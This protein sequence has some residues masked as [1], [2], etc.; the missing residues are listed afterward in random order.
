MFAVVGCGGDGAERLTG[1]EASRGAAVFASAGCG[2]CHTLSDAG[3]KGTTGPDLDRVRLDVRRVVEQV[4]RGGNGMPAFD[5]ELTYRQIAAV[6]EY[7]A[8]VAG[9]KAPTTSSKAFAPDGTTVRDCRETDERCLRQAYGNLADRDGP[10]SALRRLD[11]AIRTSPTVAQLCHPVAHTIGAAALRRFRGDVGR[12]FAAGDATCNSGYYHG[13]VEWKLAGARGDDLGKAARDVC[14]TLADAS[15]YLRYQCLHGLG[16][17]LMLNTRGDLPGALGVCDRLDPGFARNS[18]TGGV[19]MENQQ[20]SF[21]EPS[22]WMRPDD[23]LYPCNSD[24][25]PAGDKLY[26]YLQVTSQ[27]LPRVGNDW[28]RTAAW[29]RRAESRWIG[30]CFQSMGRD[31]AGQTRSD[32]RRLWEIC[33]QARP[34]GEGECLFGAVRDVLNERPDNP[35]ARHLCEGAPDAH[36]AYCFYGLGSLVGTVHRAR[37]ERERVCRRLA[38]PRDAP[39]CVRGAMTVS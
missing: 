16:H 10:R 4:G 1:A 7:L 19:F 20:P 31:A 11:A 21:G 13:L 17:G 24:V 23:L 25:V 2:S 29:C 38:S 12:A 15:T 35:R 9:S 28:R 37:A 33:R 6:A 34:D 30:I 3:S 14:A 39:D 22:R 26:C 18:C 8:R 27:I 36:R 32:L 5:R